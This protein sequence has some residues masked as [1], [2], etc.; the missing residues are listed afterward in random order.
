MLA[1]WPP[2]TRWNICQIHLVYFTYRPPQKKSLKGEGQSKRL[3]TVGGPTLYLLHS[4]WISQNV[5]LWLLIGSRDDEPRCAAVVSQA[6]AKATSFKTKMASSFNKSAS[7]AASALISLA[8]ARLTVAFLSS[9]HG[10]LL[11][12]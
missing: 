8:A 6:D 11:W 7:T 3:V 9:F 10:L 1:S 2:F 4:K 5:C 12:F